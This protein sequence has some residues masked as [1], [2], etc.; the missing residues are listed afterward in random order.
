LK[1]I[2]TYGALNAGIIAGL[3]GFNGLSGLACYFVLFFIVSICLLYKAKFDSKKF[4]INKNE[5]VFGGMTNDMLLFIMVW[6]IA[7]NLVNIL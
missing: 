3:F 5:L 7:H 2:R 6:V 4:F 1:N